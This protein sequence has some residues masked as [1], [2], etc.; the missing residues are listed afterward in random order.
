[1]EQTPPPQAHEILGSL[2]ELEKLMKTLIRGT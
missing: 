1:M 2:R